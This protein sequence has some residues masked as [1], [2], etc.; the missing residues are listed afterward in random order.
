[1]KQNVC[2]NCGIIIEGNRNKYYGFCS[3][4]C[5]YMYMEQHNKEKLSLEYWDWK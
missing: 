5:Y 1:M 2:Q 4:E 3:V